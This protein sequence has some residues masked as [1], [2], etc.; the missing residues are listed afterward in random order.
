MAG[1]GLPSLPADALVDEAGADSD[2]PVTLYGETASRP[3]PDP[4]GGPGALQPMGQHKGSGLAL[5]CELLAGALIGSGTNADPEAR[6]RNGMLSIVID[7]ARFGD[8]AGIAAEAAGFL[9]AVRATAPRA[10]GGRVLT[11]G[12]PERAGRAR[13]AAEGVALSP[14][15]RASLVAA[16]EATGARVPDGLG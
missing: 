6:F 8:P 7:P 5:A 16:S 2:R 4:P 12:E 3:A 13:G 9:E 10:E 15:L 14:G 1:A 11:P